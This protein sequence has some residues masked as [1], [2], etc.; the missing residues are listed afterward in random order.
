MAKVPCLFVGSI[1][2]SG[3]EDGNDASANREQV[4]RDVDLSVSMLRGVTATAKDG[5]VLFHRQVTDITDSKVCPTSR[6]ICC[7]VTTEDGGAEV[8]H[9]FQFESIDRASD[10]DKIMG[11]ARKA[12]SLRHGGGKKSVVPSPPVPKTGQ[13]AA[14]GTAPLHRRNA[15]RVQGHTAPHRPMQRPPPPRDAWGSSTNANNTA[16][17]TGNHS[18]KRQGDSTSPGQHHNTAAV[19]KDDT[20][21]VVSPV[22]RRPSSPLPLSPTP[23][24]LHATDAV[25]ADVTETAA[26][27]VVARQEQG[28]QAGAPLSE[29]VS[30][31]VQTDIDVVSTSVTVAATVPPP[32]LCHACN[33]RL[34]DGGTSDY[35]TDD[36]SHPSTRSSSQSATMDAPQPTSNNTSAITEDDEPL[37]ERLLDEND[38]GDEAGEND[39]DDEDGSEGDNQATHQFHRIA[40]RLV[41]AVLGDDATGANELM[42]R[43]VDTCPETVTDAD[44]IR[45][46]LAAVNGAAADDSSKSARAKLAAVL[47]AVVLRAD[48]PRGMAV[49]RSV[50]DDTPGR[51][52]RQR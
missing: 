26:A 29:H 21:D 6:H 38:D 34:S 30:S 46:A 23:E 10:V 31:G 41:L 8:M 13:A 17:Y 48:A 22:S 19:G 36:A 40:L 37:P 47:G 15:K 49:C 20:M 5:T 12:A 45:H 44:P 35:S 1:S 2:L 25:P 32:G 3:F 14:P 16:K 51:R 39:H 42:S 24:L 43:L 33:A 50:T 11:A 18:G 7:F 52:C 28:I 4:S 27:P 9:A